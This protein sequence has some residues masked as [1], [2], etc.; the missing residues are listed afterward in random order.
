M[1]LSAGDRGRLRMSSAAVPALDAAEQRATAR[2]AA[3][4]TRLNCTHS[5]SLYA[6]GR[7]QPGPGEDTQSGV[8]GL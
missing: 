7:L 6:V 8:D 1:I 2:A 5:Y 3:L 4:G